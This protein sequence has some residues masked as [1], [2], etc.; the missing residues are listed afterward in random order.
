M[1]QLQLAL[2]AND[3][4]RLYRHVGVL[5]DGGLPA[6]PAQQ[7]RIRALADECLPAKGGVYE[8]YG[9]LVVRLTKAGFV[10]DPNLSLFIKSQVTL[11]GIYR[12]LDP[13]L[14]PDRYLETRARNRVLREFPKRLVL[15]PAWNYRGY[16]S[17]M[18]NGD[19][20]EYVF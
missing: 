7:A 11:M 15:L 12:E 17:L 2:R 4:K 8:T 13:S 6:D 18:S 14:N 16:R 19:V 10:L 20:F 3:R 5:L 9:D 1:V